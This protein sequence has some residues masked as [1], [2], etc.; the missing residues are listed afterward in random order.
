[1]PA[2]LPPILPTKSVGTS[3][4][5]ISNHAQ[6]LSVSK[7]QQHKDRAD[8]KVSM[9]QILRGDRNEN[10][11]ITSVNRVGGDD[12]TPSTS[13]AHAGQAR[14]SIHD[15]A[16]IDEVRDRLR[17]QHIRQKMLEK[18][19]AEQ[20]AQVPEDSK[21][22]VGSL[23]T[24]SGFSRKSPGA[25]GMERRLFNKVRKERASLKNLSKNDR[26]YFLDMVE[27]RAKKVKAGVG[28]G[29]TIR[30]KMKRQVERDRRKGTISYEDSKDFKRMIDE[31]PH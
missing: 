11:P 8:A 9:G 16:A 30:K 31:F 4:P 15:D 19:V 26:K 10:G 18:K 13:V 1:M 17:Y 3:T 20:A 22:K 28:F 24:G 12:D 27:E 25:T 21:Y 23:A 2:K 7:L 5:K 6:N 29:R 14:R